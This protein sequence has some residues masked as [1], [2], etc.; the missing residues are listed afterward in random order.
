[1]PNRVEDKIQPLEDSWQLLHPD[2]FLGRRL[3]LNTQVGLL[4]AIDL[5]S[6]LRP[7]REGKRPLWP[8]GEYLGKFMQAY[9]RMYLYTGNGELLERMQLIN[10]TWIA[11]QH[12]DGWIGT[13]KQWGSW[14][15]WEHKYTLLGLLE[16][17]LLTGDSSALDGAKK[18]GNLFADEFGP[19]RRDLMRTGSWAMGAG[20]FLES[21][22]YLYRLTGDQKYLQFCFEIVREMESS[23]GP[24]LI[25]ILGH[26]S[27]RVYDVV[28]PLN[29]WHNGR[30]GYEMLA[31]LVGLLRMHQLT[32]E[33]D[34]LLPAQRAWQDI[35]DNRLYVTGTT[36]TH[37]TFRADGVLPGES[38][39]EV[40]EGCVSAYWIFLNRIL[41]HISG[42]TK[43]ADEIEKTLYNHLIAS[44]RPGDGYQAYFTALNGNRPCEL[45]QIWGGP[46]PCCLSSVTRSIARIPESMWGRLSGG[47]FALLLYNRARASTVI[48]TKQGPLPVNFEVDTDFPSTGNVIVRVNLQEPGEFPLALRVPAWTKRFIAITN[49]NTKTGTPGRFLVITKRWQVN[50]EVH[51]NMDMNDRLVDGAPSYAG[52]FA[53]HHGPQ[54]LALDGRLSFA[55]LGE[56]RVDPG[57]MVK[58]SPVPTL[59]PSGWIGTQAYESDNLHGEGKAILV[60]F[61]DTGQ[62]DVAHSYR[63]WIRAQS[64][65]SKG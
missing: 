25:A 55:A 39:D 23:T 13:G 9:S 40:G 38:V 15:V 48:E 8:S 49:G 35:V 60:P 58:L 59:L 10:R 43:Y 52:Y 34:Y 37:E 20:S 51:I 12:T 45:Q 27:G 64:R 63:T 41:L 65:G 21:M 19:G 24:K 47:G 53:F 26:G 6:Y 11:C 31:S 7:Y 57:R 4:Q 1:M 36:T 22:V 54:V 16:H 28:D 61:S 33:P 18:I 30:K 50:D 56:V 29:K 46:P 62:L 2:S 3:D 14:D 17:Y 32:G 42:D 44:K 5:H